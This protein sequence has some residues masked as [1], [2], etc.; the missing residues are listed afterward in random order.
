MPRVGAHCEIHSRYR[1]HMGRLGICPPHERRLVAARALG[2]GAMT[3]R[4]I[5]IGTISFLVVLSWQ[6][7]HAVVA[8]AA[9]DDLT[10]FGLPAT[11]VGTEGDDVLVGTPGP[12]V[13]VG[14]GGNDDITPQRGDDLVC[15]GDGNDRVADKP[16]TVD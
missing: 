6:P 16:E 4:P 5:L 2:G 3:R 12:D 8:A 11:I 7:A 13:I 9:A 15:A 10:C 1:R 14:L